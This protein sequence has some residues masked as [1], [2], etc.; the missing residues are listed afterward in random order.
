LDDTI[1]DAGSFKRVKTDDVNAA[2]INSLLIE[3][4]GIRDD[5]SSL[6]GFI[7]SV[8]QSA[9]A[10]L[11]VSV[12]AVTQP[13]GGTAGRVSPPINS[14]AAMNLGSAV[15]Q[16]GVHF[17]SDLVNTN[18]TIFI[19][20]NAGVTAGRGYPLYNGDQIFIETDNTSRIWVSSDTAG[21]TLYY[22]G[23]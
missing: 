4:G 11:K 3:S 21:T 22:I 5:I 16:S 12:I 8:W 10:A 19:G 6:E 7:S 9:P 14:S 15:L 17:K 20:M 23:T 18:T 13:S 2:N 1:V